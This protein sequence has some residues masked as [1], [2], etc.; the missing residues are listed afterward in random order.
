MAK[1]RSKITSFG[2]QIKRSKPIWAKKRVIFG[3]FPNRGLFARF[4]KIE[5]KNDP[6][7]EPNRLTALDLGSKR[8]YF[9]VVDLA[10]SAGQ[11]V[12][13]SLRLRKISDFPLDSLGLQGKI[14]GILPNPG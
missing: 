12:E 13:A 5:T 2:D 6:L 10:K 11:K 4:G 7:F 14:Q 9:W 1:N 8:G 3:R